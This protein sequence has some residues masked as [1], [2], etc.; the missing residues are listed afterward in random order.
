MNA[1]DRSAIIASP[2]LPGHSSVTTE[3]TEH[4]GEEL[5]DKL[6][7]TMTTTPSVSAMLDDDSMVS[8]QA[9]TFMDSLQQAVCTHGAI[10]DVCWRLVAISVQCDI[11]VLDSQ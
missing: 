3:A 11:F 4:D 8:A 10:P 2:T 1:K 9:A 6:L 7:A 5:L